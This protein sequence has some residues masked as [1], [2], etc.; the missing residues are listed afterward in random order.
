[1]MQPRLAIA[2]AAPRAAAVAGPGD[3]RKIDNGAAAGNDVHRKLLAG[4]HPRGIG[5]DQIELDEPKGDLVFRADR[6]MADE[7]EVTDED[8]LAP[9]RRMTWS[10]AEIWRWSER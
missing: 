9:S 7:D 10:G 1:M 5:S 3:F 4:F 2:G 6:P 8:A